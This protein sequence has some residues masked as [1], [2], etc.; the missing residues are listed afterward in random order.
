MNNEQEK[1]DPNLEE[2]LA[3]EK[4]MAEHMRELKAIQEKQ[5]QHIRALRDSIALRNVVLNVFKDFEPESFVED[6]DQADNKQEDTTN[7]E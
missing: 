6:D 7:K 4:Q 1:H 5:K 3:R 2:L